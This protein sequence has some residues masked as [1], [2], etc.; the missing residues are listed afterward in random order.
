MSALN[1]VNCELV[2]MHFQAIRWYYVLENTGGRYQEVTMKPVGW[3][4]SPLRRR[5]LLRALRM[6]EHLEGPSL[7]LTCGSAG[8]A[9]SLSPEPS[10]KEGSPQSLNITGSGGRSY[11]TFYCSVPLGPGKMAL[12]RDNNFGV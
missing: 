5:E 10:S 11:R 7:S 8:G 1:L 3:S 12:C 9:T 6:K 4:P 2:S